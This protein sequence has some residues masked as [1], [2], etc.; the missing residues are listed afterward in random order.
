M[1][2]VTF[3]QFTKWCFTL[4]FYNCVKMTNEKKKMIP[5]SVKKLEEKRRCK[6]GRFSSEIE[7][8]RNHLNKDIK[9]ENFKKLLIETNHEIK[10]TSDHSVSSNNLFKSFL[11]VKNFSMFLTL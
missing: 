3:K 11:N 5:F 2:N 8:T 10:M 9:K 4:W 7:I 1:A 6:G